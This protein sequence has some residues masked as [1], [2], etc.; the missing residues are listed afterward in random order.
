MQLSLSGFANWT[1]QGVI[2][3]NK[4]NFDVDNLHFST[5][6]YWESLSH[7]MEQNMSTGMKLRT[8]TTHKIR[9]FSFFYVVWD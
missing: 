1:G 7:I 5:C 9:K 3:R 2:V 4:S 6:R 8:G